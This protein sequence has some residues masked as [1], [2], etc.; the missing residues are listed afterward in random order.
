MKEVTEMLEHL[1]F[2]SDFLGGSISYI[3][4]LSHIIQLALK[5]L[6]GKIRVTPTNKELLQD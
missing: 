1:T 6:L 5:T 4:C 3:P 2:N